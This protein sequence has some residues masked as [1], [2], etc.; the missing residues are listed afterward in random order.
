MV[1]SGTSLFLADGAGWVAPRLRASPPTRL[2][3]WICRPGVGPTWALSLG[4]SW[5]REQYAR[6][7]VEQEIAE[8]EYRLE[9][10]RRS[11]RQGEVGVETGTAQGALGT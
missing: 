4:I 5:S 6:G 9:H 7:E 10:L 2:L 11:V 8:L 1:R 3:Y